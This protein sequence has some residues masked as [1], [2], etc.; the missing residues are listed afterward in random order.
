MVLLVQW[1]IPLTPLTR[2]IERLREEPVG[3]QV[4]DVNYLTLKSDPIS[5]FK[6]RD[7]DFLYTYST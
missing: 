5:N 2:L 6:V 7:G 4:V 1:R 3:R